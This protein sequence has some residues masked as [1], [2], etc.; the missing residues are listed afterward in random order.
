MDPTAPTLTANASESHLRGRLHWVRIDEMG[1]DFC[2]WRTQNA[3]HELKKA[4]VLGPPS[5]PTFAPCTY[6][7]DAQRLLHLVGL[8]DAYPVQEDFGAIL[9]EQEHPNGCEAAKSQS[10]RTEVVGR[11]SVI[12]KNSW[13]GWQEPKVEERDP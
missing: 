1:T 6:A 5:G 4:W 13:I 8:M 7:Q 12:W 2:F 9:P 10:P 11:A 3:R